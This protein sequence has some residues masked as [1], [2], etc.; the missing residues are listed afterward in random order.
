ML[1]PGAPPEARWVR[2]EPRRILPALS[3]NRLVA[4]V[5]GQCRILEVHPL[6]SGFRNTN[7]KIRLDKSADWIVVRIYEHDASLCQKEHDL[8]QL[9]GRSVP[10]PDVIHV[11]PRGL[12]E[13]PPFTVM[14]FVDG[15]TLREL[16]RSGDRN[17]TAQAVASVGETLAAI[18]RFTFPTSG[19]LSPGPT[20]TAALLEG[21]NP[22]PRFV[23]LCLASPNLQPRIPAELRDRVHTLVWSWA[24]ELA[25][26]DSHACLVHGDFGKHNI[27]VRRDQGRWSV[28]AVLD[29]EF[30]VSASPL[31][32]LGHFLRYERASRPSAEPHFSAGFARAGGTLPQKWQPLARAVDLTAL[33]ESLTHEPLPDDIV[34][35]LVELIRATVGN[36]DP[37]LP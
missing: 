20:V 6:T 32:D 25:E 31:A 3:L 34:T 23:D 4:H 26:L 10:L 11:E 18:G 29:W 16:M 5:F 15:I 28:A 37:I 33:C 36:R 2:A 21:A 27:L 1:I 14:R 7:L 9:I 22:T 12:E 13:I 30:A 17:A 8:I 24:P 19:W 35:E